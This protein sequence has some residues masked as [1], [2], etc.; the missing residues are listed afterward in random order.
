MI[1]SLVAAI[2]LAPAVNGVLGEAIMR[3]TDAE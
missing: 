2:A 3:L 1:R